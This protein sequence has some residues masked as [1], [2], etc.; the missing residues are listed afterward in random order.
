MIAWASRHRNLTWAIAWGVAGIGFFTAD[1]FSTPRQ[2][3]LWVA[4]VFGLVAW[5][6]AGAVT[7]HRVQRVRGLVVW[8]LSYV[9]A[10]WL[11]SIWGDEFER[12]GSA[13]FVGALLGWAVG[14]A[15]G[16]LL[17]TYEGASRRRSVGPIIVAAAWGLSFFVAGY[18]GVVAGML[19]A[20]G[21]K[22]VLAF[23]GSQRAALT[24]GWALGAAIGGALA[25]AV[26]MAARDGIIGP[27]AEAAV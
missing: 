2:G 27:P 22:D 3:P 4:V 10:F 18:V 7:L 11:G 26:G 1:I 25:S 20:Q 6:A 17:S 19:L 24:I 15:I 5:S 16:A 14:G 21:A 13:G 8:A 23:L 12:N 9:V